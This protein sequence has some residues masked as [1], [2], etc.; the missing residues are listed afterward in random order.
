M[1]DRV[2]AAD[3]LLFLT[4]E[5]NYGIPGVI[6]NLID[7]ASR[8]AFNSPLKGKPSLVMACSLAPTG[9]ARAHGA[10]TTVLSGTL[11]PC[12]QAPSFLVPAVHEKFDENGALTDEITKGRLEK[13]LAAF[14]AWADSVG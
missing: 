10:L 3:A 1:L 7:W 12:Y 4:P 8:P 9:G 5:Y 11:T 2:T 13:T 14:V 6:K